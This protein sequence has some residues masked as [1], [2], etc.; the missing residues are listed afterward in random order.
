[1]EAEYG[2]SGS[3]LS[4]G[5]SKSIGHNTYTAIISIFCPEPIPIHGPV[6]KYDLDFS[7]SRSHF[8]WLPQA[9]SKGL[10][11]CLTHKISYDY[12]VIYPVINRSI[13]KEVKNHLCIFDHSG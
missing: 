3:F 1:M 12:L 9:V 6:H 4:R 7:Y 11:N 2:S 10:I 5:R 13:P 8:S